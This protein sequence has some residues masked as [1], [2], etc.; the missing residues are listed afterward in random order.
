MHCV[1]LGR[2]HETTVVVLAEL[3]SGMGNEN[4][5]ASRGLRKRVGV[6]PSAMALYG[7]FPV[8]RRRYPFLSPSKNFT[9]RCLRG[10]LGIFS[11]QALSPIGLWTPEPPRNTPA[12]EYPGTQHTF[13]Y[14]SSDWLR[15]RDLV[16]ARLSGPSR[17]SRGG[18]DQWEGPV[19]PRVWSIGGKRPF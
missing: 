12:N 11:A 2:A 18:I 14:Q 8:H 1:S 13:C 4:D 15:S 16:P 19:P 7:Y 9:K 6:G 17:A 3:I 10:I 5:G